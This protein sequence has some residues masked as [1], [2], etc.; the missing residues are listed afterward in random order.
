[1][2]VVKRTRVKLLLKPLHDLLQLLARDPKFPI[3]SL[4]LFLQLR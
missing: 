3:Q 2:I 1:M 4:Q